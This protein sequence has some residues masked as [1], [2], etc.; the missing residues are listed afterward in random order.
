MS[1]HQQQGDVLL[2]Q[3]A[4]G[5]DVSIDDGITRMSQGFD[6]ASYLSLFGGN[7]A[8]SN[9]WWGNNIGGPVTH[10][11]VSETGLLLKSVPATSNN[12]RRVEDAVIRDLSWMITEKIV[13]TVDVSVTI[14]KI[15]S[16]KITINIDVNDPIE[17]VENWNTG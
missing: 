2:F 4:D 11:Y 9:A 16:V 3:T 17:F 12:L 6:V 8:T 7:E 10:H 14:P 1:T 5:G 15:N 13:N